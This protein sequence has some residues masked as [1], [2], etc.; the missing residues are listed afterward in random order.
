MPKVPRNWLE[1]GGG[2]SHWSGRQ[3][4]P[5]PTSLLFLFIFLLLPSIMT[6][7]IVVVPT[8]AQRAPCTR[9]SK[10]RSHHVLRWFPGTRRQTNSVLVFCGIHFYRTDAYFLSC[11]PSAVFLRDWYQTTTDCRCALV[12]TLAEPG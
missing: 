3:L 11:H 12:A 8:I 10:A 4:T 1:E 7:C 5:G 6:R 2:C 9:T